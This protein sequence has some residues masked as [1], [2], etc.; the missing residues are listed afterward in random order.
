MLFNAMLLMTKPFKNPFTLPFLFILAFAFVEFFGGIWTQSL[1][2]LGDAWHMFFDALALGL[3]LLAANHVSKAKA[4]QK[5]SKAELIVSIVNA[6]LMLAVIAWIIL[7]AIDRIAHPREVI[8]N[9]VMLIAFIGLIINVIVA[10]QL[11]HGHGEKGFN[12][13]AA[14]L[15]VLGDLLGSVAALVAGLVI[16]LTG[17]LLIDPILSILISLL[18]FIGV[19][20]LF[21]NIW[22]TITHKEKH[23]HHAHHH[24]HHHKR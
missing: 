18:L 19:V 20:N 13:K 3:A 23:S 21:K 1:A 9:Y 6:V 12:H 4:E 17:W 14:F 2:L 11:H 16:Y 7:E 22:L 5:E 10:L 24:S 8:G 15:H